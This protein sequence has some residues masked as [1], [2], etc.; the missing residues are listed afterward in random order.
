MIHWNIDTLNEIQYSLIPTYE[1]FSN[2]RAFYMNIFPFQVTAFGGER[3]LQLLRIIESC[4]H[5]FKS[6]PIGPIGARLVRTNIST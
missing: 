4:C 2:K 1:C 5:E 3:V 6:P